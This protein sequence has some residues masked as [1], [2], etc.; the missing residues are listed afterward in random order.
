M[1]IIQKIFDNEEGIYL[2]T[3]DSRVI[4]LRRFG[5]VDDEEEFYIHVMEEEECPEITF[6][7]IDLNLRKFLAVLILKGDKVV[8]TEKNLDYVNIYDEE[9]LQLRGEVLINKFKVYE[10]AIQEKLSYYY[11][12]IYILEELIKELNITAS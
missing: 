1:S 7:S 11:I 5:N 3:S 4:R 10:E 12:S 9:T 2:M 8:Y 6:I